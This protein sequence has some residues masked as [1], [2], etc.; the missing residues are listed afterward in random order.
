VT[1]LLKLRRAALLTSII[2]SVSVSV[3]AYSGSFFQ[4]AAQ[5]PAGF[6][7]INSA[8]EQS[9]AQSFVE[10]LT[11][12][13]IGFL[14]DPNLTKEQ[15]KAEFKSLLRTSFD[16]KTIGRF[17]LGRYWKTASKAQQDEYIKLFE[18]SIVE[19]YARR[20]E[21]YKGQ[22]VQVKDARA[23]GEKDTIVT[24][25]IVSPTG[26][27]DVEVDWRVRKTGNGFKVVDVIVE[28]VSM[29]VT[30]R[31]DFASVIQRGGGNLEVLLDH[32]RQ[33]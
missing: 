22:A 32:L 31:S 17:T 4:N 28:G 10:A 3:P 23:E 1:T 27:P 30:Q 21:E 5:A 15:R 2:G 19:S 11:K 9:G 33:G 7:Q 14:Q 18:H 20:F 12:K 25:F 16:M 29:A 6:I 26:G 13:G 24:S 8:E